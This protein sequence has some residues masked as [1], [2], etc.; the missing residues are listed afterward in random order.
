M[1]EIK[2]SRVIKL[3]SQEIGGDNFTVIA[4]PCTIENYEDVASKYPGKTVIITEAG[5]ATNSNGRGIDPENVN[6][7][8]QSMYYSD[9]E[10]WCKEE[11]ILTFVFEA[12]D[13]TW[14][15][16]SEEMEP[17]KHWGLFKIDRKPKK[18]MQQFYKKSN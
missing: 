8:Y 4:G 15:G 2:K 13:E 10:K 12:F 5:W 14:K 11:D 6:E 18:V 7:E 1:C 17:E 9:L 3:G 16:S